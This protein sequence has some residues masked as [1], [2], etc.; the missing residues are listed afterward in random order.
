MSRRTV[1]LTLAVV[2]LIVGLLFALADVIGLGGSPG[3]GRS[4]II[5]IVV[6]VI[7]IYAVGLL[8][9]SWLFR[10]PLRIA[11]A[12]VERIPLVKSLYSALRDLLQFL[13]GQEAASR[14]KPC[15]WKA[16]GGR[17]QLLGLITQEEPQKFLP[18]DEQGRIAVYLPMSYQLG[19]FTFYVPPDEVEEVKGMTVEEL[20]KLAL[21]AGIG[22]RAAKMPAPL[23]SE[24]AGASG[25]PDVPDRGQEG[26][27]QSDD[28][29]EQ[30]DEGD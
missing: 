2:G 27:A 18:D 29:E 1:G 19:G 24:G 25:R 8:A 16:S 30:Q 12:V 5:G 3:F 15:V 10:W 26:G 4:Q 21:T 22:A 23:A 11:E 14:G 13:G 20:L 9:R 17:T 28:K 7:A 6:G